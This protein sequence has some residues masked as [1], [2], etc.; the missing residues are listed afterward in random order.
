MLYQLSYLGVRRRRERPFVRGRVYS[1]PD[2][3]L[4]RSLIGFFGIVVRPIPEGA[5]VRE[6]GLFRAIDRTYSLHSEPARA[7]AWSGEIRRAKRYLSVDQDSTEDR[8]ACTA[9]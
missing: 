3:P 6:F 7:A 4:S 9:P 1:P 2:L 8:D 5:E